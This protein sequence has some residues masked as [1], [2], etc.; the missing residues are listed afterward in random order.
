MHE[1]RYVE[2]ESALDYKIFTFVSIGRHGNLMKIVN[3]DEITG[4]KNV[5]NLALG[6]I[7]PNGEVDFE[8]VANNG[9]RNKILATV[10]DIILKFIQRRPE[11][12]IF[13]TGSDHRRTMLY[14][15]AIAYGY[16]ELSEVFDVYG[17]TSTHSTLTKFEF[18]D[19]TK[20][21]S[22]FLIKRKKFTVE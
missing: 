15:R 1:D 7:L 16:N 6:T 12:S 2:V 13:I 22:A 19:K 17:D 14:Q 4:Y 20:K 10:V 8:T 5:F 11:A 21:Y 9:D 3:F 18:F